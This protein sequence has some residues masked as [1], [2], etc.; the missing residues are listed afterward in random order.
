MIRTTPRNVKPSQSSP[1]YSRNIRAAVL[2]YPRRYAE[3]IT[4]TPQ[5][6]AELLREPQ[7]LE[8]PRRINVFTFERNEIN[9]RPAVLEYPQKYG[10]CLKISR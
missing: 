4:V 3:P 9:E 5:R 10:E 2:A 1:E 6:S 8:Y 7:P